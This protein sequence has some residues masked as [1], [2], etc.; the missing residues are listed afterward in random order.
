MRAKSSLLGSASEWPAALLALNPPLELSADLSSTM[1]HYLSLRNNHQVGR[2]Q[3]ARGFREGCPQQ[4][5][6]SVAPDCTTQTTPN[7]QA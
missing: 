1:T 6:H 2:R 7:S 5:F 3:I 4:P